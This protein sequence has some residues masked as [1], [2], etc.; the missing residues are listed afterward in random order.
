VRSR[1]AGRRGSLTGNTNENR[2]GL[3]GFTLGLSAYLLWGG[4][5]LY[6]KALASVAPPEVLAHR[7]IWS[8]VFLLLFVAVTRAGSELASIFRD[9]RTLT[10]LVLTALLVSIN[11]FVFISAVMAGRVLES[12]LGYFINP[13]VSVLLAAV[14]LRERLTGRQWLSIALAAAGVT[15]QT[16]MVGSLP[17]ISLTLAFTFGLYGLIRKAFRIPAVTGLAV[18]MIMISPAALAYLGFLLTRGEA[19]FLAGGTG[20]DILLLLAGVVTATP[21]ILFGGALNRLRLTTMGIMQYIVPTAHFA[22]AVFAF[23]ELFTLGHMITFAFIWVGL[24]LYTY[25]SLGSLQPST[26]AAGQAGKSG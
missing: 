17:V 2:E 6:F 15:I 9:R 8:A 24:I 13:L 4:F 1:W 7:I 26:L 20:T 21:L 5:P 18:E 25:E 22:L 11:W 14:F 19:S 12:S 16:V 10:A 3:K 23:G